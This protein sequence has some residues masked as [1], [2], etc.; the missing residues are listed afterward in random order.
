[1]PL[2]DSVSLL[3]SWPGGGGIC[4]CERAR[5]NSTCR[6]IISDISPDRACPV[7]GPWR[8]VLAAASSCARVGGYA[9]SEGL[10]PLTYPDTE[11]G[12]C[13]YVPPRP[14]FDG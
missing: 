8:P 5:S 12:R 11:Y 1:M 7:L 9:G 10:Y 13:S 14:P 2:L 4:P 6:D 3:K